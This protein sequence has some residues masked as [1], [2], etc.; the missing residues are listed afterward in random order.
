MSDIK[1]LEVWE[2]ESK[3]NRRKLGDLKAKAGVAMIDALEGWYAQWKL[4]QTDRNRREYLLW[5]LRLHLKWNSDRAFLE[6][7]D[8][9]FGL[10][11]WDSEVGDLMWNI[12]PEQSTAFTNGYD[13]RRHS[14]TALKGYKSNKPR[15]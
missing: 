6:E 10:G 7:L 14:G 4:K 5:R 2:N 15:D 1:G 13:W 8:E 11:L 12:E 9:A 3:V